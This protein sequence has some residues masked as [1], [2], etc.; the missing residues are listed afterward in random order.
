MNKRLQQLQINAVIEL[1]SKGLIQEALDTVE[2]LTKDYPNE[3]FLY[4]ISGVCFRAID[5][6]DDAVSSFTK[7]LAI[8]PDYTEVYNNLGITLKELGQLDDAVNIYMKA[9]SINPDYAEAHN[10]F[11]VTL[12]ELG[13]LDDAIKSYKKALTLKPDYAEAH[14]NL[15]ITLREV[16][17]IDD[18]IKSF[19]KAIV[20]KP[21]YAIAHRN[22]SALKRY[23]ANDV[24]IAQMQALLS[25][26]KLSQLERMHLCFA[27]AKVNEDLGKQDELFKVLLEGNSLRKEQ[28]SYSH[29]KSEDLF[30]VVRKLFNSPPVIEKS[31]YK[32]STIRPVF[33]VGMPRSGTTLVEQIIASH[34]AVH[35]AGE[36]NTL[37]NFFIPIVKNRSTHD[38]NGLS[39][40]TLLSIRQRYLDSLSC[41]NV[42]EKVITDKMPLN[43]RWIG[44]ILTAFPE[45]KIVHLKRDA[46]ATCWSIYKN[47]FRGTGIGWAY[48]IEDLAGFYNLYRDL[49]VFWNQLYPDK[50]Y[51]ICY[52]DLTTNQEEETRKL[53]EYCELEWDKNCLYFHKNKRAVK[54]TSSLQ[55]RQKMYQGS[56]EAWKKHKA[57]L[58]P[59]IKALSSY[60]FNIG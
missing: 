4:N 40:E 54:T 50:I 32:A 2:T 10:S 8:Q 11:G 24:Q 58:Q 48:N 23:T 30:S 41:F 43:F 19:E 49:M 31:A 17:Q 7:A 9:L 42:P 57:Y 3:A 46:M 53:L 20:C 5:R 27:L 18:A 59:L 15:G 34:H 56:S 55:V 12:D 51:D 37:N 16:G 35:G 6:L 25:S 26:G 47:Y 44:F 52:E 22:L 38:I 1:Y 14:N 39:E 28:L 21:D 13:Q 45:A 60:D 36:L 33:I 29:D